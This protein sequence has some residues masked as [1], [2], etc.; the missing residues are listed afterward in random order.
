M[1][2][3]VC[4]CVCVC[5]AVDPLVGHYTKV[6]FYI[7]CC[8]LPVGLRPSSDNGRELL[9]NE[10]LD[11]DFISVFRKKGVDRD[12][13][14]GIG[15]RYGLDGAGIESLSQWPSGLR[16]IAYWDWEFEYRRGHGCLCCVCC[17]VR[18]KG[19]ARTIRTEKYRWSTENKKK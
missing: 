9:E 16:P 15:T 10:V 3:C 19:K 1:W 11:T 8:C 6:S 12:S 5:G 17:T 18:T 13:S 7:H 4:V 14:V 2:L